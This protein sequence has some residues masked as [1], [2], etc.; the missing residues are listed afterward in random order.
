MSMERSSAGCRALGD[1][2][3]A[4]RQDELRQELARRHPDITDI[5]LTG[6]FSGE[7]LRLDPSFE[8][9]IRTVE[10]TIG[11]KSAQELL[12]A[13]AEKRINIGSYA[14]SMVESP[15][16]TTLPEPTQIELAITEARNLKP[17]TSYPTTEQ[18]YKA[19]DEKGLDLLPAEAPLHHLLKNGDQMKPGDY[20]IAGM[21]PIAD[22]D[23]RPSV[24]LLGRGGDGLWLYYSWANP[25]YYG[26]WSPDD[27]FAFGL[28]KDSEPLNP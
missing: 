28:R 13:L 16:F 4:A 22:S 7:T 1:H 9:K 5:P 12:K 21:K 23:G 10:L 11:G 14:R 6:R 27:Q 20:L 17:R 8:R 3:L 26:D 18:I 19:A 24:F 15:E 25:G 2:D